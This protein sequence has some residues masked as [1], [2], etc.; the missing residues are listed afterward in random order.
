VL[1]W[2]AEHNYRDATLAPR[3]M[4]QVDPPEDQ[5]TKA[6]TLNK[7]GMGLSQMKD[8]GAPIDDRAVLESAGMPTITVEEQAARKALQAEEDAA[9]AAALPAGG[10]QGGGGAGAVGGNAPGKKKG[11]A[12][13]SGAG[14]VK[15]VVFA[16]MP[17]AIENPKGSTRVW[18]DGGPDG[19]ITGTTEMQCDYGYVEGALGNDST[20]ENPE[21]LDCYLGT[22]E[23]AANVHVVHQLR[24]PGFT[25]FDE[26][27]VMLGFGSADEAKTAYLAHRDD[28]ERAFGG[29]SVIPLG[30]FKAKLR[31]RTGT[32]K[33][34]A[35]SAATIEAL[36]ALA[37]RANREMALAAKSTNRKKLAYADS[38]TQ[39]AMKLG[40]RALAVDLA[41]VKHEI[42]AAKDWDDLKRRMVN[43]FGDRDPA[44]LAAIIEK[45]RIMANLGGRLSAVK[46]T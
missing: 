41:A 25:A 8:A 28:G 21:E 26:D 20:D 40:A 33:I 15:R 5:Q 35:S 32:G 29:M 13:M 44:K 17:I 45:A 3:P 14:V 16:G 39:T 10:D 19:A 37:V 46:Q 22:Q 38:L 1:T 12:K 11:T 2:D 42:D 4:W 36:G 18:R 27:K 30:A 43:V 23:D 6:D 7:M 31:R 24:A 34:R 9:R